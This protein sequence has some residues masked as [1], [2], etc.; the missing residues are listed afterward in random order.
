V[1]SHQIN[2]AFPN[3]ESWNHHWRYS[4]AAWRVVR[5]NRPFFEN[6]A[7]LSAYLALCEQ[8]GCEIRSVK[9]VE[10]EGMPRDR[11]APRFRDL[12]ELDHKTASAHILA[13]K[14]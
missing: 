12:P 13:V 10:E 1:M 14:R 7:P 11:M 8:Y 3:G 4:D 9:R 6:R 5:G 2:F